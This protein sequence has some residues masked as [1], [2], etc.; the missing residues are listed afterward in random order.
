[1]EEII[2]CTG[3]C[4]SS[5]PQVSVVLPIFNPGSFLRQC[6]DSILSQEGV[7][8]EVICVDDG[9]T[10]ETPEV[11][12]AYAQRDE[13]VRVV[14]QENAGA[15]VA[16]NVGLSLAHGKY[17]AFFD[18]DD[19][20]APG[21]LADMLRLAESSGADIVVSGVAHYAVDGKRLVFEQSFIGRS[22]GL[23][24][25]FSGNDLRNSIF[26]DFLPAPWN[27]LYLTEFLCKNE[28]E[29][30]ALPRCNDLC[31]TMTA[32]ACA[33]RIAVL[34]RICYCYR[35]GVVGSL[36]NTSDED[37]TCVCRAYLELRRQLQRRGLY[38]RY[39]VAYAKAAV[40]SLLYTFNLFRRMSSVA[41]LFSCLRKVSSEIL[42][43]RLTEKDFDGSKLA[44]ARY[45][46][47]L[48]ADGPEEFLL[49]ELS[50][51]RDTV[52]VRNGKI[53]LL[54]GAA[55]VKKTEKA[56]EEVPL[57]R[58]VADVLGTW[59]VDIH[60]VKNALSCDEH[61]LKRWGVSV[62]HPRGMRQDGQDGFCLIGQHSKV[63][64]SCKCRR[65][66]VMR[67]ALL[68]IDVR[69]V[70]GKSRIPMYADYVSVK[71]SG[72]E[73]LAGRVTAWHG[74]PHWI[75]VGFKDGETVRIEIAVDPHVYDQK[76]LKGMLSAAKLPFAVGEGEIDWLLRDP[77]VRIHV[78]HPDTMRLADLLK[79]NA[80]LRRRL[81]GSR[82]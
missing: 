40:S 26:M 70:D 61:G 14:T 21:A 57:A 72:E 2:N 15:G 60:H 62:V 56:T 65:S 73:M 50:Y 17:T 52:A 34:N 12:G 68:G 64:F 35:Q 58:K 20:I 10:D 11:L 22:Q 9:S 38:E 54:L 55:K 74:S 79:E 63:C 31:F 45:D 71:I 19:F 29:F 4:N 32:F 82:P 1:M 33:K 3:S 30:Q 7:G 43:T 13:R 51:W 28:L 44:F 53:R 49:R 59:R 18:P 27:K 8:L 6:L 78:V 23:E 36:Q 48:S 25:V 76:S 46:N 69:S 5:K 66:G 37:P 77:A 39:A 75:K 16:R 47:L 41:E 24:S 67:I 81:Q 42:E 80:A